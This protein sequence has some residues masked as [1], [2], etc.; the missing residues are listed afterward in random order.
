M[1]VA[2]DGVTRDVAER[3]VRQDCV[4]IRALWPVIHARGDDPHRAGHEFRG[5]RPLRAVAL[6]VLHLAVAA[7][8]QPF[9]QVLFVG[10]QLG[11]SDA[12]LL[13]AEF[14]A[15]DL[16]LLGERSGIHAWCDA[17]AGSGGARP[18]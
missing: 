7:G 1:I 2:A 8:G 15:P 5:S 3:R 13:E 4:G 16:D 12:H 9:E 18:V 11:C 14:P 17:S 6:H 10:G